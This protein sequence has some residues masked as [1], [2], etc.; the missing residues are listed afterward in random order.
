MATTIRKDVALCHEIP[1]VGARVIIR[2]HRAQNPTTMRKGDNCAIKYGPVV[3][4]V[5]IW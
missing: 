2:A 1:P 4:G 3:A 5:M